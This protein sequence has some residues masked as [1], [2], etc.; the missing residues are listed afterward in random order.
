MVHQWESKRKQIE[1][2]VQS[3][4]KLWLRKYNGKKYIQKYGEARKW[5]NM[6]QFEHVQL[7]GVWGI[8]YGSESKTLF[9]TLMETPGIAKTSVAGSCSTA[10]LTPVA[11]SQHPNTAEACRGSWQHKEDQRKDEA[12]IWRETEPGWAKLVRTAYVGTLVRL[13][14]FSMFNFVEFAISYAYL[15]PPWHW[16]LLL[17]VIIE[18]TILNVFLCCTQKNCYVLGIVN[19]TDPTSSE[20]ARQVSGL[21][22]TQT[23]NL[24]NS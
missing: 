15:C 13:F 3:V 22:K 7:K 24:W 6:R 21:W 5:Q 23:N 16:H 18:W 1:T 19:Q 2:A 9:H 4:F 11:A 8:L 14:T 12:Y 17:T 10:L 20:C